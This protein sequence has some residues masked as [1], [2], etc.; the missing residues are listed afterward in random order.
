MQSS[1]LTPILCNTSRL[2]VFST[3]KARVLTY[4]FR[5][6]YSHKLSSNRSSP[7]P[8][9]FLSH[10]EPTE[11]A[12]SSLSGLSFL[13]LEPC[14]SLRL[15]ACSTH[16]ITIARSFEAGG[17]KVEICSHAQLILSTSLNLNRVLACNTLRSTTL[18]HLLTC[19]A[20]SLHFTRSTSNLQ[21]HIGYSS[22]ILL[23]RSA[24]LRFLQL[25]K[26]LGYAVPTHTS[27]V[28]FHQ[29][30]HTQPSW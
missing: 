24:S 10:L 20:H 30:H 1:H 13:D 6:I 3:R 7:S 23:T 16:V 25:S 29:P 9:S 21:D 15:P 8:E 5:Q 12:N 17:T 28:N 27:D 18:G 2:T 22:W 11:A 4:T 14:G 26:I 19:S